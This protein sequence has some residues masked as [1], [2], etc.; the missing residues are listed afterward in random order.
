MSNCDCDPVI[1][2]KIETEIGLDIENVKV[3]DT[4]P[5]GFDQIELTDENGKYSF[6]I[7]AGGDYEITPDKD[8]LPLNGV[9]TFDM[10]IMR[11][12]ILGIDTLDSPY[13]IIAADINNSGAV[14][15][16]DM[17]ELRKLI[18]QINTDFPNNKSWRFVDAAYVFPNPLNPFIEPFPESIIVN[19]VVADQLGLDFV[20]I[21]IGDVN[22]SAN[23]SPLKTPEEAHED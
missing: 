10:V 18:L 5:N 14:T 4:N 15:T 20:G 12:H 13:K 8:T 19:D 1:G 9:T 16:F 7:I 6:S 17:V 11:K 22:G 23:P 2:G 3:R 21:K